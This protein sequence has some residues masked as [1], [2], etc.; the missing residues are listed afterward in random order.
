MDSRWSRWSMAFPSRSCGGS[1][2]RRCA[3]TRLP[4]MESVFIC[5]AVL[6]PRAVGSVV[7]PGPD[8]LPELLLSAR[9]GSAVRTGMPRPSHEVVVRQVFDDLLKRTSSVSLG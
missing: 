9:R 4:D 3:S 5:D 2:R 6:D 8:Q 7:H 1:R